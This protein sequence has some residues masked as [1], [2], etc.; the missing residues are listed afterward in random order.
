MF[1]AKMENTGGSRLGKKSMNLILKMVRLESPLDL[2]VEMF[3]EPKE[4]E[5]KIGEEALVQRLTLRIHWLSRESVEHG[6][7]AC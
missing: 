4:S 2:G 6:M 7:P 1:L 5:S 3:R